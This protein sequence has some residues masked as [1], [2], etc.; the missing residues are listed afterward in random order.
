[1]GFVLVACLT[2]VGGGTL[3]GVLLNRAEV[4]WL[5]A[6]QYLGVAAGAAVAVCFAAPL[7]QGRCRAPVW[8]DA[9]ALAIAVPAGLAVARQAGAGWPVGLVMGMV[10][11]CLGVLVRD[12]VCSEEPLVLKAGEP[13]A[14]AAFA[15]AP[16]AVQAVRAGIGGIA[17]LAPCAAATPTLRAGSIAL[18]RRL[19]AYR[20][21]PP[22]PED[23]RARH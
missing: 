17:P 4:F 10:T 18:G 3:R 23:P 5:A 9:F 1:V 15:G 19:H 21:R 6:P 2:A 14:T 11:G 16:T 12:V 20:P 22:R 8:R 7:L 13:C